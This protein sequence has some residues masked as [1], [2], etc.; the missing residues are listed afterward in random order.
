DPTGRASLG[1][2]KSLLAKVYLT[3]AGQPLNK[4]VSHYKLAADKAKEVIA[5]GNFNLFSNYG[6]LHNVATENRVEHIFEIQYLVGVAD[7][8]FQGILLPNFKEISAFGTEIGSCVPT[9]SFYQSFEPGDVRTRT[10]VGYFYTDYFDGGS[11][12][13]KN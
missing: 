4:G 10:R 13:L 12:P 1:A 9:N 2:V 8:P 5:S 11:G 7:N 3:M 6:D